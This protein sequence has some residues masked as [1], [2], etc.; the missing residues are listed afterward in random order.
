MKYATYYEDDR[1]ET[2]L[3][4]L[5]KR[6][7]PLIR[8]ASKEQVLDILDRVNNIRGFY[9]LFPCNGISS[10]TESLDLSDEYNFLIKMS[11]LSLE[12]LSLIQ[13]K[14]GNSRQNDASTRASKLFYSGLS[15]FQSAK[16]NPL[17]SLPNPEQY[18]LENVKDERWK[19]QLQLEIS[20][21]EQASLLEKVPSHSEIEDSLNTIV[22]ATKFI[23]N[24]SLKSRGR[25]KSLPN[26]Y[27]NAA[28]LE[29][30][31]AFKEH[32]PSLKGRSNNTPFQLVAFEILC[33]ELF[34]SN[35]KEQIKKAIKCIS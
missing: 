21:D 31:A 9:I 25:P 22:V 35:K 1:I 18:Q 14:Y 7:L 12:L 30:D 26:L 6:V 33:D 10:E 23:I 5:S 8:D 2:Y 34:G 15:S 3:A 27:L 4:A 29:L 17:N 16:K 24:K 20:L 28:V 13:G 19:K 32:F 11:E